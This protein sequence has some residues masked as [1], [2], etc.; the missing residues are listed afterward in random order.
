[1]DKERRVARSI[2][3]VV[4]KAVLALVILCAA[5]RSAAADCLAGTQDTSIGGYARLLASTTWCPGIDRV[6]VLG[7][8]RD[9][10]VTCLTGTSEPPN[11]K[12]SK[13][14]GT[15]A[16]VTLGAYACGA[17][18]GVSQ[19]YFYV[20]DTPPDVARDVTTTLYAGS[21]GGGEPDPVQQCAD[22]GVDY[23]WNG[24]DCVYSPGSPIIIATGTGGA[25]Q[26]T[27]VE[28]GVLFDINGDGIPEQ[29]AWTEANAEVAFLALD[30]DGDGQ[31][32]SGKELFG[33]HTLPGV[34]NG[35]DA[36]LKTAMEGNGGRVRGS[37]DVDDPLFGKLLLWTDRNH[38]G[39]SEPSELRLASEVLSEIGLG[40]Q[41]SPRRD[42]FGNQ[43]RFQGWARLRTAPGRNPATT[44]A[45]EDKRRRAIWDVFFK[46]Q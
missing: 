20:G 25:Y 40:Y 29:I 6:I 28:N 19:H 15:N 10:A 45:E 34:P 42:R 9:L 18:V 32:T 39:L 21:C 30:R 16:V 31:I 12:G 26:L 46:V 22:Q 11:C 13:T 8:I 1:M 24:S 5:P 27:P 2:E 43:F 23:Y 44:V 3:A 37:I 4:L 35:F 33:N 14:D 38:N 36:L 17:W 41:I 7:R